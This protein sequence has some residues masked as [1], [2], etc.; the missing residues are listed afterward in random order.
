MKPQWEA[1]VAAY[2]DFLQV[3]GRADRTIRTRRWT[4]ERFFDFLDEIGVREI[5]EV[6]ASVLE[7]FR[8]SR[9]G[10]VNRFGKMDSPRT[11]AGY[12]MA[13]RGLFAFLKKTGRLQQDPAADF[14]YPRLPKTLP[15]E[16]LTH[17][18]MKKMLA[19]ADVRTLTGFRDRAILEFLYST[20]LRF[21]EFHRLEVGDVDLEGGS[22][23]VRE[24]K[25]R[26]DRV[27]PVGRV[28]ALYLENYILGVRPLLACP[29][30]GQVLFLSTR[31]LPLSDNRLDDVLKAYAAKAG[32]E[33]RVSAHTMRRTFA[34]AL[35]RGGAKAAHVRDMMGHETFESLSSYLRL[36][37][38]D[39]KEAH[40][41]CHPR[42]QEKPREE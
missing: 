26:K 7:R 1:L 27:V 23:F 6:N 20:G 21:R 16:A 39:L 5:W 42:E 31:G 37:I 11:Q 2:E 17:D 9:Y 24:G 14:E 30:S 33:K 19:Q 12:V 41:R 8:E 22:V 36:T 35:F 29:W 10:F 13:V 3:R 38:L 18:E 25:G 4:L 15:R 28:A 40:A 34:T 32:I